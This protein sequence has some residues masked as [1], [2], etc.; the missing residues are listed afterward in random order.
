MAP[1][2]RAM[3]PLQ[4]CRTFASFRNRFGWYWHTIHSDRA[5]LRAAVEAN[6]AA[7]A[8]SG[9]VR[10]MDAI[11]AQLLREHQ[12]LRRTGLNAEPAA[13]ALL[14][15]DDDVASRLTCHVHL[16]PSRNSARLR[17]RDLVGHGFQPC[18]KRGLL[19]IRCGCKRHPFKA[20]PDKLFRVLSGPGL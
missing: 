11:G 8:V 13:L 17:N 4:S 10:R 2:I 7:G 9:V 12:T 19:E 3:F 6:A 5:R 14:N 1:F 16:A 15:V 18:R 20:P